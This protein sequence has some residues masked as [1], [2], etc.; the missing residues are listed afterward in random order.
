MQCSSAIILGSHVHRSLNYQLV[1]FSKF[2][3]CYKAPLRPIEATLESHIS[4]LLTAKRISKRELLKQSA[5]TFFFLHNF[6]SSSSSMQ[7]QRFLFFLSGHNHLCVDVKPSTM[8]HSAYC[9]VLAKLCHRQS[10]IIVPPCA[11]YK[12]AAE[13]IMMQQTM[14]YNYIYEQMYSFQGTHSVRE[15]Y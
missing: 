7:H 11:W 12:Q 1:V 3:K 4:Y 6:T 9:K 15:Y 13:S 8:K 14:N 10:F 5:H 2:K